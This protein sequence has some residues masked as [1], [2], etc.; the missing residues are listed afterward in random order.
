MA[1]RVYSSK[2]I[3]FLLNGVD[4]TSDI[5]YGNG[6]VI[7]SFKEDR[8]TLTQTMN[9]DTITVFNNNTIGSC[10]FKVDS[11]SPTASVL[12]YLSQS[13]ATFVVIAKNLAQTQV[14]DTLTNASVT[15]LGERSYGNHTEVAFTDV[16]IE[17]SLITS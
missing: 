13:K 5:E 14:L 17:G 11:H 2:D 15:N 8:A 1:S 16:V 3:V 10:K 6:A 12:R 7:F 4:I 9:G